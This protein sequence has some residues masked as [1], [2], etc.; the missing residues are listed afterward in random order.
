MCRVV[1]KQLWGLSEEARGRSGA[2]GGDEKE[3]K[4]AAKEERGAAPSAAPGAN[5]HHLQRSTQPEPSYPDGKT[6]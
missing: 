2:T 5:Y 3:A 6:Q 4:P 1:K